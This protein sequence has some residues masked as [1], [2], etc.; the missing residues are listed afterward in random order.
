MLMLGTRG[1]ALVVAFLFASM[2]VFG[3]VAGAEADSRAEIKQ[4]FG[5]PPDID[6]EEQ[7]SPYASIVPERYTAPVDLGIFP[8]SEWYEQHYKAFTD[9]LVAAAW[10]VAEQSA[11]FGYTHRAFFGLTV[12]QKALEGAM[13]LG[14]FGIIGVQLHRVRRLQR[15]VDG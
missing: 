15:G 6:Y 14:V 10:T 1:G 9:Q 5:E 3:V 13:T 7:E 12:V 2:A 11:L 8:E 4:Q